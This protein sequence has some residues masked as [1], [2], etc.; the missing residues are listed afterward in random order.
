MRNFV[1]IGNHLVGDDG[2]VLSGIHD[3]RQCYKRSCVIHS[4]TKHRM[5][6]WPLHYRGD[7]KI[8][9]RICEHGIG[10]PDPDQYDFWVDIGRTANKVHGC[11]GCC[12]EPV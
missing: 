12:S 3:I 5:S 2:L 8:F 6:T 1:I 9:E 4:P 11:D 10:H 7:R